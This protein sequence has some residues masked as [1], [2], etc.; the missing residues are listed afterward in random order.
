VPDILIWAKALTTD[1]PR[2]N[3]RRKNRIFN[4]FV[5]MFLI[6]LFIWFL[7]ENAGN[8]LLYNLAKIAD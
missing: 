4:C 1:T 5:L 6:G 7:L 8:V 3:T 2:K